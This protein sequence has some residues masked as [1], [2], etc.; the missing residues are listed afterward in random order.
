M[1]MAQGDVPWAIGKIDWRSDSGLRPCSEIAAF[2]LLAQPQS[3]DR[4][5]IAL[6]ILAGEVGEQPSPLADQFEQ[7]TA[8]MMIML[9]RTQMVSEPIDAFGQERDLDLRRTRVA[10]MRLKLRDDRFFLLAL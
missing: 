1:E 8:R 6:D 9:V 4:R 10:H 7:P 3:S 5:P 2:T